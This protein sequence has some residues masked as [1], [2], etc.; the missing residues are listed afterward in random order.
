MLVNAQNLLNFLRVYFYFF[1]EY[2]LKMKQI[3]PRKPK[4]SLKIVEIGV[5]TLRY[6][7]FWNQ[8]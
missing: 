4:I 6:E 7:S 8:C 2:L 3:Y 1:R 5:A